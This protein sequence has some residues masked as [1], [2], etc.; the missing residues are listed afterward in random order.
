MA[1][2]SNKILEIRERELFHDNAV[3]IMF[4]LNLIFMILFLKYSYIR[5][6]YF[7]ENVNCKYYLKCS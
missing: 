4:L 6:I 7:N 5:I 2:G 1:L 3:E